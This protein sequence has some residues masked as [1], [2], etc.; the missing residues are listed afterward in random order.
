MALSVPNHPGQL[1]EEWVD[2]KSDE[3]KVFSS[4]STKSRENKIR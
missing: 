1:I 2:G 3:S 4:P